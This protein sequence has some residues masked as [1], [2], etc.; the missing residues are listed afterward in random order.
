MAL[1]YKQRELEHQE[2]L[3]LEEARTQASICLSK[4]RAKA[5]NGALKSLPKTTKGG[6]L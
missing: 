3:E 4:L 6:Y 2:Q 1:K 5:G